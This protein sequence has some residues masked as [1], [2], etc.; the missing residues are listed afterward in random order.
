MSYK[1]K[2]ILNLLIVTFMQNLIEQS[3]NNPHFTDK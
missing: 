3:D 1:L 2:L